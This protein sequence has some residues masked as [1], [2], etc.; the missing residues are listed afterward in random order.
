MVL[1]G[2]AN[3]HRSAI[4]SSTKRPERE[5]ESMPQANLTFALSLLVMLDVMNLANG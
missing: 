2:K 5:H 1:R 4:L 3:I